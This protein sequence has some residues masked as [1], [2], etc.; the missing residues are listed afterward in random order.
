LRYLKVTVLLGFLTAAGVIV[1][2]EAGAFSGLDERLC[3]FYGLKGDYLP[4][5]ALQYTVALLLSL[6]A[7]WATVDIPRAS[8]KVIVAGIALAEV[9]CT[10]WV[11]QL[12]GMFFSPFVG[13]AA[14]ILSATAGLVYSASEGGRRKRVLR[15]IFGDRLSK[16][17]FYALVNSRQP[18]HFSGEP[19]EATAVVCEILNHEELMEALPVNDCVTMT[20]RLLAEAGDFLVEAG[21]YLDE[22]AGESLRVVF[23]APLA[24]EQHAVKACDA[25]LGL[26]RKLDA[27]NVEFA[28]AKGH[29]LDW[30][31]GINSGEMV[32]AAYGSRRLGGFSVSGDVAEFARRLCVANGVFGS[33]ILIGGGTFAYAGEAVEVRPMDIIRNRDTH[34]HEEIYELLA[35][36]GGLSGEEADRRDMFWKG[37]VYYR[38]RRWD[39]ALEHFEFARGEEG[40]ES[41]VGHY[42]RRIAQFRSGDTRELESLHI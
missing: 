4:Q 29:K 32:A 20:N 9:F 27:L 14:V 36:K 5:R 40:E 39:E 30:R 12:Y 26:A 31:I 33:R 11:A 21:G 1:L 28:T 19:C 13:A 38:E 37:V 7:A 15:L 2:F 42:L 23:G 24:D 10:A 16:R 6:G 17:S 18:L 35:L 22:C 8:L 41:P 25:V 3:Q 34:D